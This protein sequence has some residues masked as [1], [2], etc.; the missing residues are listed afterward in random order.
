[1]RVDEDAKKR[2][3]W[4]MLEDR[5]NEEVQEDE[6]I[7]TCS[8]LSADPAPSSTLLSPPEGAT[9]AACTPVPFTEEL[10]NTSSD[11]TAAS[12]SLALTVFPFLKLSHIWK[13]LIGEF[14]VR[15]AWLPSD[16]DQRAFTFHRMGEQLCISYSSCDESSGV[17]CSPDEDTCTAECSLRRI[18]LEDLDWLQKRRVVQLCHQAKDDSVK[19]GICLL[20]T[21]L[22]KPEFLSEG[23]ARLKKANQLMQK[24]MEY[25]Y[26]FIIPEVVDNE[27]EECDTDL[28][29]QN[30]E[31][32]YDYVRHMHQ[33]ESQK[34]TY[35]VQHKALIPVLRPY[36][37]QAVNWMLRREKYR[38]NSSK[39]QS[40]HFLWR[41]LI[42]LCGKKLFYNPFI[43]CLIREFPLAG[44]EW[45]GGILAD[46]MGLGKTVEVLALILFHTRQDLEQEALTLPVGKS[47]NYFVPPPPLERKK[48]ISCKSEAQPKIK[49]SYPS[50]SLKSF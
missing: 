47:V 32:L 41:E 49:I 23:N 30:V 1:M 34:V 40:L 6:E 19:V 7:P 38:I 26:D 37:S 14:S 9:E 15:P 5:K 31:E 36:Q 48:V 21:G 27:E 25:F 50:M 35:D 42:A 20:E 44:V 16:C 17:Q 22:G 13:A 24:L 46:E 18:P 29:R 43:G 39:E 4:N 28:E 33:E 45:P 3:N 2:L 12:T 11:I 10:P 8:I